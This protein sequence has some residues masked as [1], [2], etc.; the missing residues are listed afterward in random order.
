MKKFLHLILL[1]AVLAALALGGTGCTKKMKKAYHESRADKMFDAGNFDGAE[2]EYLRVLRDDH[3]NA[4]AFS[5]LGGI[6]FDQGRYQMAAPFLERATSLATNDLDLRVKLCKI[7]AAA[8]QLKA[9]RETA[10]F[11]LDRDPQSA[12]GPL[13]LAQAVTTTKEI[14]A[15]RARLEKLALAGDRAP[16]QVALGTLAFHEGDAKSAEAAFRRALKLDAKSADALES[17][18]ALQALQQDM[19]SAGENFKAAADLSPMRSSRRMVYARFK[20]QAGE[21]AAARQLLDDV[22]KAAPDYIPALMGLGEMALEAKKLDECRATLDKVLARDPD[23][24]DGGMLNARL[25]YAQA[26]LPGCVAVLE[27]MSKIYLQSTAVHFQLGAAYV[28][29]GDEPKAM[30]SLNRALEL[31]AG[32][33]QAVLLL[34]EIQVK[35]RNPDPAIVS[36]GKLVQSQPQLLP[37]HLLLADAYRLRGQVRDAL[38]VYAALEKISPKNPQI[39][40]LS[41]AA[42]AQLGDVTTA[43]AA[44]ERALAIEPENA[45]ALEQLVDLDLAQKKYDAAMQRLQSRLQATPGKLALPLLVAKVQLA[46]GDRAA[47]E[48]TLLKT[49]ADFPKNDSPGLL[50]AQL[51][52]DGKQNDQA[53]KQLHTAIEKNPRNLPAMMLLATISEG[54]ADYKSAAEVY[55]QV[56]RVEPKFSPALNNLAYLCSEFLG[57]LDRAY[58]LAQRTRELLPFDPSAAD[59]LGWILYKRGSYAN[60]LGLLHEGAAKLSDQPEILFHYGMA[61]YMTGDEAG[62]RAALQ[63]A[64]VGGKDFRG[65]EECRSALELLEINPPTAKPDDRAKLEKR[66]AEKADDPVAQGRLAA[67]CERDGDAAR[68]ISSYEAVLKTDAKNLPALNGLTRLWEAKDAAKAYGFAKTAYKFSPNDSASAHLYGRL[69]YQNGELKLAD[70]VLTPVAKTSPENFL[71]QYD[72]ARAA[73]LVGKISAAQ[74]ALQSARSG[75]LPAQ[76]AG[77]AARMADL[78]AFANTPDAASPVAAKVPAILQ[79]EPDYVP[80]LMALAKLKE[81]SGDLPAATAACEKILAR[82]ADFTP[83][84]RELAILYSRDK[85]KSAQAY[86]LAVKARDAYPTDPALAKTIGLIVFQQGDFTRAASLLKDCAAKQPTD[87]EIFYYLGAAQAKLNQ[88]LSA[89]ASLDQ[90]LNLKLASPLADSARQILAGLK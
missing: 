43:R 40:L 31:D 9:A 5:R 46:R 82:A 61:Q 90:A 10:G 65:R 8:G 15:A 85:S 74:S 19:K 16:Y 79:A 68:A 58:E 35:N 75:N 60:A 88:K 45:P 80:A 22:V 62:A 38:A 34:A 84:Q 87:P 11:I 57:Q 25:K 89:K 50:L 27:R 67:I 63:N 30:L 76:P 18:G 37:A 26:D 69:A 28:A 49:A 56:L 3:E 47:A 42:L 83:A 73:Y 13:L 23:N 2:I 33:P 20:L 24:F 59:T 44:F 29:V 81:I 36:L 39:P 70:S 52:Y 77:E 86:A 4:K 41:G 72:Y 78:I 53:K 6:Y 21:P 48:A 64:L 17:L 12:A 66:V 1:A 55:D 7:Y 54:E 32:F 71:L 51:Y 14:A